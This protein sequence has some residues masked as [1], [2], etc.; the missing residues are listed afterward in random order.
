MPRASS[1]PKRPANVYTI[2]SCRVAVSTNNVAAWDTISESDMLVNID[3][4]P[5]GARAVL[6]VIWTNSQVKTNKMKLY[7]RLG[8]ADVAGSE[9]SEAID[10]ANTYEISE[11]SPFVL[12]S[13]L[14]SFQVKV[15][16]TGGIMVAT[17]VELQIQKP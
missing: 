2:I 1:S 11:S 17:K 13:G 10:A 7:D 9:F 4:Y 15:Q 12:P 14:K 6:R 16:V 3:D 8:A 5:S